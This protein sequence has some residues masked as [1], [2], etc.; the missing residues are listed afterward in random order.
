MTLDQVIKEHTLKVLRECGGSKTQAAR[1]LGITLK[2]LYNWLHQWNEFETF[3]VRNFRRNECSQDPGS[4]SLPES[5]S[6]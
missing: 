4:K 2:S 3:K 6:C 1:T 5:S